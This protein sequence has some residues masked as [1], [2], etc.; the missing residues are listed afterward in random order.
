MRQ[1]EADCL[2]FLMLPCAAL[3]CIVEIQPEPRGAG[4]EGGESQ[5]V[6]SNSH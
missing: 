3:D 2:F 6:K 5:Q 4:R 1:R